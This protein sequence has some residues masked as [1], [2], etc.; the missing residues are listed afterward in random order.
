M[1]MYSG[2][3]CTCMCTC[4]SFIPSTFLFTIFLRYM[5]GLA[6]SF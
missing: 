1:Y 6:L 4:L 3:M 5:L 2:D